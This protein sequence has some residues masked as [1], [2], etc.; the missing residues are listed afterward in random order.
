MTNEKI[1]MKELSSQLANI[2]YREMLK[3]MI[4]EIANKFAECDNYDDA[5][6]I[7]HQVAGEQIE[8]KVKK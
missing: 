4:V 2:I 1:T 3:N 7:L 6:A 5:V 8:T